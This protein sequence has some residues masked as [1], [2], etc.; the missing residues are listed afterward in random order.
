MTTSIVTV[1]PTD[2]LQIVV[3]N[4]LLPASVVIRQV[5][6]GP[7]GDNGSGLATG[8]LNYTHDQG[9]ASASWVINHALGKYPSV[10]VIDSSGALCEGGITYGS[11]NQVTLTFSA[12]FAG[13]AYLN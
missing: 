1:T 6:Q 4:V 2:P 5:E 9:S 11:L 13:H 7:K 3:G 8:D 12:A 10:T